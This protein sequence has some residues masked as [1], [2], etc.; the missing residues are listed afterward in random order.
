MCDRESFREDIFKQCILFNENN[1]K[2]HVINK[3]AKLNKIREKLMDKLN[4]LDKNAK[5][6]S[7]LDVINHWYFTQYRI[8]RKGDIEGIK[9]IKNFVYKMYKKFCNCRKNNKYEIDQII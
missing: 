7:P 4:K 8:N 9:V 6:K 5:D 3:C 2:E 1:S